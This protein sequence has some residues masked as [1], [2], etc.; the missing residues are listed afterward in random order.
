MQSAIPD[1][2]RRLRPD[3]PLLSIIVFLGLL[4]VRPGWGQNG[5]TQPHVMLPSPLGQGINDEPSE[6]PDQALIREKML[7]ALNADRQ[8]SLVSDTNKLLRLVNEFNAE[9]AA[10]HP[11]ALTPGQL[12]KMAEIEKLARSVREKMSTSVRGTPAFAAPFQ[13]PRD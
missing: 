2:A 7:R 12:S 8:K 9:I 11:D 13:P 3:R 5:A 4:A 1:S 6:S 10:T